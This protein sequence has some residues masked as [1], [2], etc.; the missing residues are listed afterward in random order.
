MGFGEPSQKF[1]GPPTGS[2]RADRRPTRGSASCALSS[3]LSR[4]MISYFGEG[5]KGAGF[6]LSGSI[7]EG[8]TTGTSSPRAHHGRGE[9]QRCTDTPRS[10]A[11]QILLASTR[12][13]KPS[14]RENSNL[15]LNSFQ[16]IS[17]AWIGQCSRPAG[18][19]APRGA[20]SS[21]PPRAARS[22][23]APPAPS[24]APWHQFIGARP[25]CGEEPAIRKKQHQ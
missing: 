14:P 5:V 3:S 1:A 8:V 23:G 7:F 6:K 25:R 4:F 9:L 18:C 21:G 20:R 17:S 13:F 12:M 19:S 16:V 11:R 22:S 2:S 10:H 24:S 15:Q